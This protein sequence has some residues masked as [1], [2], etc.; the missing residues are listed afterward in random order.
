LT[1]EADE[2]INTENEEETKVD[3]SVGVIK[4][5]SVVSI[6]IYSRNIPD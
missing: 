6:I 4:C 3:V 5:T 1:A 2:E